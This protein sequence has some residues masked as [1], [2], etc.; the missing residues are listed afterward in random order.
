[1][2]AGSVLPL[3]VQIL[4]PA[5]GAA[6]EIE[7]PRSYGTGGARRF[8]GEIPCGLQ[9]AILEID[10]HLESGHVSALKFVRTL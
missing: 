6:E 5:H 1:M 10:V 7:L 3:K 8:Q 9:T 4:C 2:F